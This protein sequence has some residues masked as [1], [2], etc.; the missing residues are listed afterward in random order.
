MTDTDDSALG[1]L[2]TGAAFN[3]TAGLAGKLSP[4]ATTEP[5]SSEPAPAATPPKKRVRKPSAPT[6]K[7]TAKPAANEPTTTDQPR[8]ASGAKSS[9]RSVYLDVEVRNALRAHTQKTGRTLTEVIL[10]SVEQAYDK[11]DDLLDQPAAEPSGTSLFEHA[12]VRRRK[13]GER[14][15]V[16]LRLTPR[17]EE[18]LD[19]IT[20][21]YRVARSELIETA[22]R[23]SLNIN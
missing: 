12:T 10:L 1:R 21:R 23:Y 16:T 3:R 17:N 20:D 2:N 4:G 15:H 8:I 13:P 22:L 19:Q 6:A 9:N 14:M 18:I 11:L 5:E 7:K